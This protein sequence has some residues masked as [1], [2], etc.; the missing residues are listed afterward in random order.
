MCVFKIQEQYLP[1]VNILINIDDRRFVIS[2]NQS[3]KSMLNNYKFIIFP[4]ISI[5]HIGDFLGLPSLPTLY[6]I[7]D[8]F[9]PLIFHNRS[10][11]LWSA[12]GLHAKNS[13]HNSP[14]SQKSHSVKKI[15]ILLNKLL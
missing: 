1:D 8:S 13:Y 6:S 14:M 12:F 15:N 4:M 2:D 7:Y 9:I 11:I 10:Y 5:S 3:L